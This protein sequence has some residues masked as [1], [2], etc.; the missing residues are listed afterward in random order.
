MLPVLGKKAV[1][2]WCMEEGL[3]RSSCVRNVEQVWERKNGSYD[4]PTPLARANTSRDVLPRGGTSQTCWTKPNNYHA[5]LHCWIQEETTDRQGRSHPPRCTTAGDDRWIE[6]IGV[7]NRAATFLLISYLFALTSENEYDFAERMP[8]LHVTLHRHQAASPLVRVM[9][10]PWSPLWCSLSKLG[11]KRAKSYCHLVTN[12][13]GR[14]VLGTFRS[15]RMRVP[16][17]SRQNDRLRVLLVLVHIDIT[18]PQHHASDST[19]LH[20]STPTW[21]NPGG[22][23]GPPTSLPLPPTTREDLGS[24]AI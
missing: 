9:G 17:R 5:D 18:P 21:R 12:K 19:I 23:Q 4:N 11:W 2:E 7:M 24:T 6:R 13:E 16:Y 14:L 3:I 22:G 15:E 10:G 1:L 20:G 8:S